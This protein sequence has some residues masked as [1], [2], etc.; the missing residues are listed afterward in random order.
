MNCT[1]DVSSLPTFMINLCMHC[2]NPLWFF[3]VCRARSYTHHC[4]TVPDLQPLVARLTCWICRVFV[5]GVVCQSK[6]HHILYIIHGSSWSIWECL[7]QLS[8]E[9]TWCDEHLI[10]YDRIFQLYYTST[11]GHDSPWRGSIN[12]FQGSYVFRKPTQISNFSMSAYFGAHTHRTFRQVLCLL[13]VV[14]GHHFVFK[15]LNPRHFRHVLIKVFPIWFLG[16]LG[17]PKNHSYYYQAAAPWRAA[18]KSSQSFF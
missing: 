12:I 13:W 10:Y 11:E 1:I 18:G 17:S 6:R 15:H 4:F 16:G 7:Q 14:S 3:T 9:N 2:S 8:Q 5:L